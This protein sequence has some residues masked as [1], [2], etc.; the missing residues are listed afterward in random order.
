MIFRVLSKWSNTCRAGPDCD[1]PDC[2]GPERVA[3]ASGDRCCC[4]WGGAAR[5]AAYSSEGLAPA[6]CAAAVEPADVPTVRS[7]VVTSIPASNIPAIT[8]ISHALPV[9]PPPPSTRAFPAVCLGTVAGFSWVEKGVVFMGVAF[10]ELP[11]WRSRWRLAESRDRVLRGS[12]HFGYC[13]HG[14][15]LLLIDHDQRDSNTALTGCATKP[16][17]SIRSGHGCRGIVRFGTG[18]VGGHGQYFQSSRAGA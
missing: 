16:S 7:A 17:S 2:A 8:P 12:T 3:V 4:G 13:V 14:S 6:I 11:L 5:I 1:G 15:H 10:R 18:R 9:D